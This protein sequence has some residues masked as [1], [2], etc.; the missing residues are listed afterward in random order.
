MLSKDVLKQA[1]LDYNG[2][3]LVVSHDREFLSEL[4]T[5]TIEFRDHRLY[6]Y[7]GDVNYFLD[8]RKLDNM[9]DVE[10]STKSGGYSAPDDGVIVLGTEEK[11]QLQRQVQKAEKRI[12]ELEEA[13]QKMEGDMTGSDFYSRP[14]S[15]DMM[16]KYG[17]LKAELAQ[18]YADWEQAVEKLA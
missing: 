3:L 2:T 17:D 13:L 18:V 1:L 11:K 10:K 7:L 8:K 12:G 5:R 9:R 6:E 16:K 14:E 4:T 15:N